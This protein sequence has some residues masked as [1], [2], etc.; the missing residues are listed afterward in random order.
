MI[1]ADKQTDYAPIYLQR[2][3]KLRSSEATETKQVVAWCNWSQGKYP[4]LKLL[5][6]IANEGKRT[7][8][9]AKE[10]Q[11]QGLKAGVPDLCL[12]VAS[13]DGKYSSLY[14]EMK[15]GTNT[16]S[17]SQKEFLKALNNNGCYA[18]VCYDADSAISVI[19]SYLN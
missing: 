18:C 5:Y 19:K 11:R 14:I 8:T 2:V 9:T 12:P 15:W 17:K 10:L 3:N 7:K 1:I 13:G 4:Q 16:T 6:H